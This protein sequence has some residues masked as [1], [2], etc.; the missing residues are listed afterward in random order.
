MTSS[1]VHEAFIDVGTAGF[2]ADSAADVAIITSTFSR[3]RHIDAGRS[4]I[5][6]TV[7]HF[8]LVHVDAPSFSDAVTGKPGVT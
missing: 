2:I 6:S 3:S 1:I 7:L 4:I 5:A 8:T